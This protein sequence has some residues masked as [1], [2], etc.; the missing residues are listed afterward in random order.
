MIHR[1]Q[2]RR[3]WSV[4]SMKKSATLQLFKQGRQQGEAQGGSQQWKSHGVTQV[5]IPTLQVLTY[6]STSELEA[7]EGF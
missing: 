6:S 2:G 1:W 7:L 5:V 3:F 4:V